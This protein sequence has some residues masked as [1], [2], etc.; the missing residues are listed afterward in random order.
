MSALRSPVPWS[1]PVLRP[2][3]PRRDTARRRRRSGPAA[4]NAPADQGPGAGMTLD[5]GAARG[6]ELCGI[7]AEEEAAPVGLGHPD[8]AMPEV[9]RDY[10]LAGGGKGQRG[11]HGDR[12]LG[13]LPALLPRRDSLRGHHQSPR[14]PP[15]RPQCRHGIEIHAEPAPGEARLCRALPRPIGGDPAR[16]PDQE[17]AARGEARARRGLCRLIADLQA[18]PAR[19]PSRRSPASA[20]Y[21]RTRRARGGRVLV[22]PAAPRDQAPS[23]T[24]PNAA[25]RAADGGRGAHSARSRQGGRRRHPPGGPSS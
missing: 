17:D 10:R 7:A 20:D 15:L 6:A 11:D 8:R 2:A 18:G 21:S 12:G 3:R 13:V 24:C 14:R 25:L 16:A 4:R 22:P 19:L 1:R 23:P 5:E 9:A